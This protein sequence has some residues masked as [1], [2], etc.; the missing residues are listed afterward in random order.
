MAGASQASQSTGTK[1]MSRRALLWSPICVLFLFPGCPT[2]RSFAFDANR[3][4]GYVTG[5]VSF[6]PRPVGTTAHTRVETYILDQLRSIGAQVETDAFTATTPAGRLKMRN[7]IAKFPGERDGVIVIGSH[8]ETNF[9]LRN[10][11]GANDGASS[12]GLLLELANQLHKKKGKLPGYSV[13][14]VWFDGEEAIESWSA[15]DSLYGS[16]HLAEKWQKDGTLKEIRAFILTDMIGDADLNIER[17]ANSNPELQKLAY[18]AASNLGYQSHFFAREV[19]VEDDHLP[20]VRA[21]VPSIDL[22]DLNYGPENRFHHTTEDTLD[23]LSPQSLEIVGRVVLE[24]VRLLGQ[25]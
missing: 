23:K 20:F 22:I 24:M 10:F 6:G 17:D 11:V 19:P 15:T 4:M 14:L 7:I 5:I 9:P 25:K 21:G 18:Q 12:S 13:W 1:P 3:A 8:Y 16:R 2:K